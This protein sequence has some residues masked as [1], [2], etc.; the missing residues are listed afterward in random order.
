VLQAGLLADFTL[1]R[2]SGVF[3]WLDMTLR[4]RPAVLGVLHQQNLQLTGIGVPPKN[5]S[6]RG[7]FAH[8][9]IDHWPSYAGQLFNTPDWIRLLHSYYLFF[10]SFLWF[11]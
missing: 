7:S 1:G 9:L 2:S 8:H 10:A 3:A 5:Y 6:A 4:N 11:S